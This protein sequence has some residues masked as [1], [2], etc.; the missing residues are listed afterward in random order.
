MSPFVSF[1]RFIPPFLRNNITAL[2]LLLGTSIGVCAETAPPATLLIP[3][4]LHALAPSGPQVATHGRF[5]FVP[6][7]GQPFAE[8][9]RAETVHRPAYPWDVQLDVRTISAVKKGDTLWLGLDARR[10]K[11]LQETGEALVEVI[12]EQAALPHQKLLERAIS[13]GPQWSQ[14]RIPFTADRDAAA[15]ELKV[16]LRLGYNPQTLELGALTLLNYGPSVAPSTLPRTDTAYE[17]SEPNHPWRAAAAARIEKV[18]KGD[19]AIQVND[20]KGRPVEGAVV[21]VRMKRH[22]FAF[23][24]AI[25]SARIAGEQAD[26][27]DNIRYR[28]TIERNFNKVVIENDIKWPAWTNTPGGGHVPREIVLRALDWFREREIPVRGHVMVWPS[29]RYTPKFLRLLEK[30]PDTLRATVLGHIAE[31]TAILG[32]RLAE[33]DVI[34]EAY[35]HHDLIDILGREAMADWF[36]AARAGA[37]KPVLFYND[38]TMFS[39]E[40]PG[41]PSQHFYDTIRF[42]IDQGAPIGGIGEQGH[43]GGSPPPPMKVLATFDR[44]AAFGL[45]IQISEFDI[46]TSDEELQVAYTRDFLTAAFS[47]PSVTGVMSWGFWAGSHWKPRAAFW[48]KDWTLRPNGKVFLDLIQRE[49]WTNAD[50]KT[51]AAGRTT[52]RGFCGDYEIS[53]TVGGTRLATRPVKLPNTGASVIV[54]SQGR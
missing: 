13:F 29:W 31:Q 47:H 15:G 49:W 11:T 6:V 41:S 54:L 43:F 53:V 45:P 18:R 52:V 21:K 34:N 50:L 27:P 3:N 30:E 10:T 19:L 26:T 5:E 4:D 8:A 16:T 22:A 39:G 14:A 12:F 24:T 35:A 37:P 36:R 9:L 38:Y 44:F 1:H 33:W 17:G 23:G 51:D 28:E 46:D 20:S 7:T 32:P 42:L 25:Q 40:G 48:A 2:C